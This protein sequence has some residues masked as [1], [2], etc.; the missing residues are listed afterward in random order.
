[1]EIY[2]IDRK[3][4][5]KKKE[6]V[7]G[8]KLIKW[9][10][11]STLGRS[12]SHLLFKRKFLSFL[13]GKLQEKPKSKGKIS[14]F[15]ESLEIDMTEALLE[16]LNEY[17]NFN[18]FFARKLKPEV[19][20]V[21]A[22]L[23]LL[24]SPA[25]GRV[26]AYDNI[27]ISK[28]VQ[29]KGLEYSL[30][31]LLGDSKLAEKYQGGSYYII[32]LCPADYHRFHFCDYGVPEKTREIKGY[33]YSVNP[34]ALKAIPKLYCQNKREITLFYSE[35]F[36]EVLYVE[37]G[38][39]AVGTIVQTF[40]PGKKVNKGEEKGYFKFGGSTVLLFFQ[41]DKVKIDDDILENTKKGFE[42][43]VNMGEQIGRKV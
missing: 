39:T 15:V 34:M 1:M 18:E 29:V 5:E 2:Y 26:F 23:N 9:A 27:E 30:E 12:L 37:V 35:N 14:K 41:K 20:P 6:I 42:T 3:T 25:D 43:K 31:E 22:D 33:Y 28:V 16:D 13:Y 4:K 11:Q 38:A 21:V 19:R 7:A 10:Y 8:D 32:R 36:G 40:K 17:Q 24:A